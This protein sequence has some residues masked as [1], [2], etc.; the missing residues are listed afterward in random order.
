[1]KFEGT[2]G[3]NYEIELHNL[4]ILIIIS[5]QDILERSQILILS[6]HLLGRKNFVAD[7]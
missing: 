7:F 6:E 5:L 1:M 2:Q 4:T 3:S